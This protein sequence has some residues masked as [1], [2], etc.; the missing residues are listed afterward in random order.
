LSYDSLDWDEQIEADARNGKLQSLY[1]RLASESKG[2]DA[3]PLDDFLV[4]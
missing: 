3:V 4:H 2:E 1:D